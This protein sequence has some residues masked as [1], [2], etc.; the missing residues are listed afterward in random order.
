MKKKYRVTLT[1]EERVMLKKLV[2]T[3][4]AAARKITHARILLLADEDSEEGRQID[5]SIVKALQVSRS[6]V[7]RLRCRF[8]EQGLEAALNRQVQLNRRAKKLDGK[9]EAFLV[10]A[11]CSKAPEGR[12]GWTLK[13]LADHLAACEIVESISPET[14]RKTLK[15]TN[16]S[17]G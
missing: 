8:V 4:K 12:R 14:V 7:E 13:L 3:G 2:S 15:K 5:A 9:A 17:L 11:A 6:T 1:E 10:A 16:L